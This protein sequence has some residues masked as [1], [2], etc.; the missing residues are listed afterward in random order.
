M[1]ASSTRLRAREEDRLARQRLSEDLGQAERLG[2]LEGALQMWRGE[3]ELAVEDEEA[4]ELGRNRG[5]ILVRILALEL[6]ERGIEP[7]DGLRRVPFPKVDLGEHRRDACRVLAESLGLEGGMR[8][9]QEN[10]RALGTRA[11]P[12]HSTCLLQVSGSPHRRHRSA[13][14]PA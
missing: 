6:R 3:V 11:E 7:R 1:R 9:V 2:E 4:A 13:P 12:R 5:D 10:T 8:F 14:R